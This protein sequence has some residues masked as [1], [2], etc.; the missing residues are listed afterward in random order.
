MVRVIKTKPREGYS[1]Y[2]VYT[3]PRAEKKAAIYLEEKSI[4]HYL[5]LQTTY[6]I[7]SDRK[8][9]VHLPLFPSYMFVYVSQHEYYEVL[10]VPGISRYLYFEGKP[11]T[12]SQKEID[13]I[14]LLL[15]ADVE[16]EIISEKIIPGEIVEIMRGPLRGIK[17][18]MVEYKGERK[19]AIRI[20]H[21]DFSLMIQVGVGHLKVVKQ[22]AGN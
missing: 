1:W 8:K 3:Q 18:E 19:V 16:I 7:W 21:I 17:G 20:K 10:N 13:K 2:V 11:A 4:V 15:D 12:I 6:R 22:K 9:K 5:P 14:K